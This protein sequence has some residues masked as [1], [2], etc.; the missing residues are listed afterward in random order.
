M[1]DCSAA[2][3]FPELYQTVFSFACCMMHLNSYPDE[4]KMPLSQQF[5]QASGVPRFASRLFFITLHESGFVVHLS[6]YGCGAG[7]VS[8]C[9]VTVLLLRFPSCIRQGHD[10]ESCPLC[11]HV[12]A[13]AYQAWCRCFTLQQS[14][15]GPGA[16]MCGRSSLMALGQH[17]CTLRPVNARPFALPWL[18]IW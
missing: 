9:G 5:L 4:Q 1:N 7:V 15:Q 2:V 8:D 14:Q 13:A 11:L 17:C 10:N 16:H 3:V 6:C 18:L 12:A